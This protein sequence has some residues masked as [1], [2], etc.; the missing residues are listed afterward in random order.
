MN[1]NFLTLGV[2]ILAKTTEIQLVLYLQC[3]VGVLVGRSNS[4]MWSRIGL[5]LLTYLRMHLIYP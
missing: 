2:T 1:V 5:V 3:T 4:Y